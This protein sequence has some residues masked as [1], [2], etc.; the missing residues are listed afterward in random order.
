MFNNILVLVD[1]SDFSLNAAKV[2]ASMADKY[3]SKLT[4]MHVIGKSFSKTTMPDLELEIAGLRA[5][6]SQ[7]L[8]NALLSIGK[9]ENEV[10][11]ILSWGNPLDIIL[12]E[13]GNKPYDL[14]VMGSRG[15]GTIKGL[16]MGSVSERVSRSVKCPVL[17]V[18]ELG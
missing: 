11:L 14:I 1:G 18:K 17:I 13:A 3:G 7:I 15:L 12:E 10:E 2:G 4:L 5:E 6:G 16:L 8:N 9:S